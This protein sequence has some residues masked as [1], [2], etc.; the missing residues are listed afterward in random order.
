MVISE[1][2]MKAMVKVL[3]EDDTAQV[4]NGVGGNEYRLSLSVIGGENGVGDD[5]GDESLSIRI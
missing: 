4:M 5:N 2:V 3:M 1:V